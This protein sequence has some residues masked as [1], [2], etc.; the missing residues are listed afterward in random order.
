MWEIRG[1]AADKGISY[2]SGAVHAGR[3]TSGLALM[4]VALDREK[5][6]CCG[7]NVEITTLPH[8]DISPNVCGGM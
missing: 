2:P 6:G 4:H 1:A 5:H 3:V 8:F 7:D